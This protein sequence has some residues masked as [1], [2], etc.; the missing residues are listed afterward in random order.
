MMRHPTPSPKAQRALLETSVGR[1]DGR[2]LSGR[3]DPRT[4]SSAL[5]KGLIEVDL[6]YYGPLYR[7]TDAGRRVIAR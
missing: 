1:E 5:D 3:S 7:I 6:Y 4:I 2:V